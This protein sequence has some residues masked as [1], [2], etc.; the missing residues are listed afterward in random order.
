MTMVPTRNNKPLL[1]FDTPGLVALNHPDRYSNDGSA[2]FFS[3]Q[4]DQIPNDMRSLL[5]GEYAPFGYI[6][7][8]YD[9]YQALKPGDV[10]D[11]TI[12]DDFGQLNLVKLKTS[13][14]KDVASTLE[15]I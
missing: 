9:I 5:D 14:L 4:A 3:L 15:V 12:V 6:I 11:T 7:N 10:I 13:T 8:G 2:E 1:T